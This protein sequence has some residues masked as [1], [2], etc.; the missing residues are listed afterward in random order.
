MDMDESAIH[1]DPQRAL[2]Y[3][4]QISTPRLVG[5]EQ[6]QA[7]GQRIASCLESFG[8]R[9]EPQPFRFADASSVVLAL[10]ILAT[11][12][13]IVITLWLHSRGSPAQTVSA[14]FLF[15][16]IAFTGPIN[17]AVQEGSL[18]SVPGGQVPSWR[19]RLT[20]LGKRY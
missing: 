5:T 11:Q 8:Y 14:L 2:H 4:T 19:G 9:V 6:E 10:E 3:A 18:A 1:Y 16:L 12:V 15:L 20:R 17:R 7:I 13:L